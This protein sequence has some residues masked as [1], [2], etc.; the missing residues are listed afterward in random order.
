MKV[1]KRG[2]TSFQLKITALIIM[3]ID[4]FGAYALFTDSPEINNHM[5]IIGRIAAPVFLFL[6]A[7]GL[8]HTRGKK[9]YIMRLYTAAVITELVRGFFDIKMGNIFQTFFYAAL[10]IACL[11]TIINLMRSGNVRPC[12]LLSANILMVLPILFAVLPDYLILRALVPS[13]LDI[14]YT[15]FFV[16]LAVCWYFINNKYINCAVFAGLA[17]ILRFFRLFGGSLQW[18]MVLAL[19]FMLLYNGKKGRGGLKYFFYI[20]YPAHQI[21]FFV[22]SA[23]ILDRR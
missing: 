22:I 23:Y 5:R 20:Y 15:Y 12:A 9:K 8:R 1:I 4:H 18:F 7:E 3:T 10:Y 13:L 11:E 6:L 19:P 17:I 21:L 16:I 14:E 2:L